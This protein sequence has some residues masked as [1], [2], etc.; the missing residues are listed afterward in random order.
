M[1]ETIIEKYEL[2]PLLDILRQYGLG[3]NSKDDQESKEELL[4]PDNN[5]MSA[6]PMTA[7]KV[8]I[9]K[10]YGKVLTATADLLWE[11]VYDA[12][13][14]KPISWTVPCPEIIDSLNLRQRS[15]DCMYYDQAGNLAAFDSELS[16]QPAGFVIRRDLLDT[17]LM[18]NNLK[19][20]WFANADKEVH[21]PTR[22]TMRWSEWTSLLI[23]DG[24]GV[25]GRFDRVSSNYGR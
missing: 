14:K 25:R 8:P 21:L 5:T 9:P 11:G 20:I 18:V 12:S 24:I 13:K 22:E 1:Y 23:Y 19:L 4:M 17:F 10:S 6:E 3:D 2:S 15:S 16:G 7:R